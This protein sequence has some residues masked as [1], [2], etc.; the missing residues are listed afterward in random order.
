MHIC[1]VTTAHPIDDVRVYEK[2]ARSFIEGGHAVSWVGPEW[3]QTN[4]KFSGDAAIDYQLTRKR[5][6][7][8]GRFL[9][10]F[11]I[12]RRAKKLP[13]VDW[14][15]APDPDSACL[16]VMLARKFK[17]RAIFDIHENYHEASLSRWL[18]PV[19]FRSVI[20][21]ARKAI[22]MIAL[23]CD[24][25]LAVNQKILDCYAGCHPNALVVRNCA[26]LRFLAAY[27]NGD[28][29]SD[30]E[31]LIMHG[32]AERGRG[33]LQVL[34]ALDLAHLSNAKVVMIDSG[35]QDQSAEGRQ[36]A[37]M[38]VKN[39]EKIEL[40]PLMKIDELAKIVGRCRAGLISYQRDLG[41]DSLPNRLFEY[42]AAGVAVVAPTYSAEIASIVN[43]EGCGIL[44]DFE[45]PSEIADAL[46][47]IVANPSGF[48]RMG[49]QGRNAFLA[50]HN[51]ESE[52]AR[53]NDAIAH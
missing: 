31:L 34:Q 8:L 33:T 10:A 19:A 29:Q 12:Y 35:N 14:F 44:A 9:S 49:V 23:K 17:S 22:Q 39:K 51:W 45:S 5:P 52:F 18:G 7:K 6:G 1:V 2:F 25:V 40:L 37:E 42:M 21:G 43:S 36:I 48:K 53:V 47:K 4:Q 50:H 30:R 32:K 28:M 41:V 11:S 13:R 16:A 46:T 20:E 24:L 38:L 27:K 3:R 26:P 15:Y